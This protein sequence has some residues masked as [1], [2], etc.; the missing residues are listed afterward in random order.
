MESPTVPVDQLNIPWPAEVAAA[1]PEWRARLAR[2]QDENWRAVRALGDQLRFD[3]S[4][5]VTYVHDDAIHWLAELP[6]CSIHAIVT[7]PPYGLIEYEEEHLAKRRNGSGG[8]WRI[9]PS[10]DGAKRS[11]LPRFTVL[12][13]HDIAE[14]H[15]FFTAV[16]YGALRAL[17]P[18]GH[19]FAASKP[20]LSTMCFHG[21]QEAGFEKRGEIIRQVQT[22]RGG[23]KP[24][25][26]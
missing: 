8:V 25:G 6:P 22:L 18:G 13:T 14:L 19:L 24:N 15:G 10:F 16:A 17:V 20:L 7:D 12:S 4:D 5:R 21:F 9:P 23:D 1:V 2:E 26:A 3:L 11:P